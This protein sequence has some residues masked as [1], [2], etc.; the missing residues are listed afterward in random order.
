MST[1]LEYDFDVHY[2]PGPRNAN[3]DYLSPSAP[4]M[5]MVLSIGLDTDLK[6]VAE[7]L[8]TGM[9][10]S[11]SSNFLKAIKACARNIVMYDEKLYQRTAKGLRFILSEE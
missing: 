8:N 11:E 9:V 3:V 4:E 5:N 10:K 2:I 6:S 7:Y 1:F